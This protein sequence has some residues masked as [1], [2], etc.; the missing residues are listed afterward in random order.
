MNKLIEVIGA[1]M[2]LLVHRRLKIELFFDGLVVALFFT[3]AFSTKLNAMYLNRVTRLRITYALYLC[4][5]MF[6]KEVLL[7][8]L[9]QILLRNLRQK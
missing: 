8:K 6:L 4:Y 2:K 7:L 5:F 9:L 3:S 1:F